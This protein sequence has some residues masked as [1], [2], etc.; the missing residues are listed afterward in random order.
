M[1]QYFNLTLTFAPKHT[2]SRHA[3]RR[4]RFIFPCSGCGENVFA[5]QFDSFSFTVIQVFWYVEQPK[6]I[7]C[8]ISASSQ[9]Y[10][11]FATAVSQGRTRS[12]WFLNHCTAQIRN[13]FV[14]SER[15][16]CV[17]VDLSDC[18]ELYLVIHF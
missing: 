1:K 13:K 8:L 16:F 3:T 18:F 4:I 14:F 2:R 7:F 15:W 5:I 9:S 12:L 6:E 17:M 10:G 11:V